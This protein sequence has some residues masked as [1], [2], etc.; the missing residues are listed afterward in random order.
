MS[1]PR[2]VDGDHVGLLAGQ[3]ASRC[4]CSRPSAR[5]PPSVAIRSAVAA[6]SAAASP[7]AT[8]ASSAREPHLAEQVEAVVRRRAVGAERDVDAALDERR[9]PARC[10]SRAS[11]WTPGNARRGSPARASSSMSPGD[12]WT[13]WTAMKRRAGHAEAIEPLQR[14]LPRGRARGVDLAARLG[15]VRLDRQVEL[16]RVHRHL[17][18]RRVADGVRR[19]RRQRERQ[20]RCVLEC[21]AG[22]EPVADVRV[23]IGN[24]C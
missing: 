12:R 17:A 11:C 14:R 13:Q 9:R 2:Q 22:G 18:P 1:T 7:V 6:G 8:L 4:R 10:R 19:M 20:P 16:A 15:E 21:V 5:A 3:R 23:R 24:N